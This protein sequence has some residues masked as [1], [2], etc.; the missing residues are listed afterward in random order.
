MVLSRGSPCDLIVARGRD[1][2]LRGNQL[3]VRGKCST[4]VRGRLDSTSIEDP[5]LTIAVCVKHGPTSGFIGEI[6]NVRE[7]LNK[8]TFGG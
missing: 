5:T 1:R 8:S 7:L 3:V 4:V 6:L 2:E